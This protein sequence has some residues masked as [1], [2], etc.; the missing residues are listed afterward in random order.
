MMNLARRPSVLL[1]GDSITQ[2][3]FSAEHR[4][5]GAHMSDWY[6][7]YADV[8][9]RGFSGKCAEYDCPSALSVTNMKACE[10]IIFLFVFLCYQDT[11]QDGDWKF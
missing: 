1:F 11:T 2:Q 9:N 6:A 7:R 4:G 5:W 8:Y 3:S 10:K